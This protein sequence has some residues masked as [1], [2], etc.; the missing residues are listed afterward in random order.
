M[1]I[2]NKE[3]ALYFATGVDNT[4]LYSGKR[5]AIGIIKAMAGEITSFDVFGG[6]GIS[7]GIAFAQAVKGAYDFEKQFQQSMKE[8]ATLSSG[9]KGSLTDFMNQVIDVTREV[10][11][12]ANNAAKALYQIVSAGHDGADGM[13]ILEAAAKA[14]IGGV[15]ETAISADAITTILN[16][17]KMDAS[18]AQEVSDQLF[19]TVRLG[20]TDFGQLGT[21]I[22]QAAPIAA[23]FGIDIREVLAAVASITKQGVPTA[24]AMTKIRAAI[25]GTANQ[26]GDAA[27]K[28][29]TFQ[30][31]LQLIYDKAGGSTMKMKELLGTDEA[32]QAALMVTGQNA[33][34]AAKDLEEVGNSA[35][36]AEAAFKEMASSAQNQ[37]QLLQNN[38]VA[39][40]RP[41]GETILKEVSEIASSFNEAFDNGNIQEAM[42]T[43]GSLIVTVTS[44]F[45][46]YKGSILAV[47]TAK[48]AYA[49][50][51]SIINKQRTIEI[52]KL[53][54]S[55]GFY[56]AE[57]AAVVKNTS[58]RILLTKALKAQF[59]AQLKS[60]S[61][62]L[63][64][65][66]VLAAA[67]AAAL[68][69]AIYQVATAETAAEKATRKYNEEQ[70]RF[71]ETLDDRKQKI[72]DLLRTIQNETETEYAQIKAYEELQKLSP[73]LT[74]AYKREELAI[75]GTAEAQ[76]ILNKE[77]ERVNYEHIISEIDRVT[78][79]MRT[80]QQQSGLNG[81]ALENKSYYQSLKKELEQYKNALDEYNR[82]KKEAEENSKPI[83]V[84]LSAAQTDLNQIQKEFDKAKKKLDEEQA[85]LKENPFYVIPFHIQIEVDNLDS[86]LKKTKD[87]IA[88]LLGGSEAESKAE[89]KN[90][91]F[92]DKQKKEADKVLKSIDSSQK[93]LMDAGNFT[94]I[95]GSVVESYKKNS[96]LLKEAEKELSVY[97]SKQEDKAEK[98]RQDTEKYKQL[99]DKNKRDQSRAEIDAQN[100]VNQS[101]IDSMEIGSAKIIAQ[102]NLNH[103]KEIEAIHREAED[104]KQ[105]LID[106]AKAE[107]E[108]NPA[109]A[110]K[111]FNTIGFLKDKSVQE[112]FSQ[113]DEQ[114]GRKERASN[115]IY[116]RG[117]DFTSL[118]DEYQDYTDKRLAIEKKYN[119][120]IAILRKLREQAEKDGNVSQL[121][122]ID[123]SIAQA[124]KEKGKSLMGLDY[125][126]LK[127]SPEYIRAFENLKETSSETLN[128]LLA[129]LE[130]A[131]QTAAEV[132]S[133]DQLR[134]YTSTIQDI[135]NELDE[136]NPFQALTDRKKELAEAEAELAEAK[137]N[138][139]TVNSGGRV[140]TGTSLNK[141]T[142]K[143]E[144]TYLTSAEALEKYNKAKDKTVKADAKVHEAERK[145]DDVMGKLFDSIK[146]LGS[147]IGG[148]A[149]E[150]IGVI[151]DIGQFALMAMHGVESASETASTAIQ[152]VEKASVILAIIS[153]AIQIAT[154]IASLFNSTDHMAEFRKEM[155]K[156]NYELEL[157][158]LNAEISTDKNSIFGDDLWGNAVKNV[159]LAQEALEKY[160]GTLD[161]ISNRKKYTGLTALMAEVHGIKNSYDSLGDSIADMQVKVQHK[162][163]FRSAKYS[164]LKDAVPEL[165]N[166]DGTV[167]QDALEKFIGS[168]TFK[169]LSEENQKYLQEMSDYWKAYEEAVD[170]VKDYLTDIFGDLGNTMSDALVDAF[171]NGTDAAKAFTDSVSDMLETLA[172][173]MIYSVTL[174]PLIEQAQEQMLSVMKNGDLSDEQKFNNYISILDG[175]TSGVLGQQDAYNALL[176]KYQEM[177]SNQGLNIFKPD[178]ESE[179]KGVSGKLEA[180]MT[181]GTA[182]ELVGLWNMTAM[183]IRVLLNLSSE[184]FSECRRSWDI[185]YSIWEETQKIASNTERTAN[186]TDGLVEKLEDGLKSVKDELSE[187]RKNTKNNN[188]S[189]G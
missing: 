24:E 108:A 4:G 126:K 189:R 124:N 54:L 105:Q 52:G 41:M 160:N 127:E 140:I 66:Y 130:N 162:T 188:S 89:P 177:A 187:I 169:K 28:G 149:G 101:V 150:I 83:E 69:Y 80:Y 64:N 137:K 6:I 122:Q 141:D 23:S 79:S 119:D 170:Q 76:K 55:Q 146:N 153:A 26:L 2:Q 185:T 117:D 116:N 49:A 151:G 104:R 44:A 156:L 175:L 136:R 25:L 95:D 11:V 171:K 58:S 114:A 180:A 174:A 3:G 87:L 178:D 70:K 85:K 120:D 53:T 152:T 50:I 74:N 115:I 93:K 179:E 22:A 163:W 161:R 12:L 48:Q 32:L 92:W 131:K 78:K 10:P 30:E 40:L 107:F 118:L 172:K 35:G 90:Y 19:T 181:E 155:T 134:E 103:K 14:A 157:A 183:D 31:A 186:N 82:I 142:G 75:L 158:K 166:A 147:A 96:N 72:E 46:G 8:V 43:L 7:A 71:L 123:R 16:A 148:E 37:V 164:S 21:S 143:I 39:A 112:K 45:V 167:N 139:D 99:L 88:T 121:E 113:I 91:D 62:M 47:N 60:T 176:K 81:N 173:Q 110:K 102:R 59:I 145:V 38:I 34:S 138:L 73:A 125:D 98:L 36:A 133:P 159:N 29:R 77:I 100:D 144:K 111:S 84:K 56:D 1:G 165:F 128:S 184:H 9:I 63:S 18:K 61:V 65:P 57:S 97:G 154:K 13:K 132:L 68:G 168:D 33:Q 17:Y 67:A 86:K 106:A 109:N 27:F 129:Q 42:K 20:K 15:T 5:E 94:G 182:S 51:T 135:M